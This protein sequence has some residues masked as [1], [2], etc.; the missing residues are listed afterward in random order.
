MTIA[1][2]EGRSVEELRSSRISR[3]VS[4]ELLR[5]PSVSRRDRPPL[6]SRPTGAS[7][8]VGMA[9]KEFYLRYYVG[10]KGKFGHEF[11]EFESAS[12]VRPVRPIAAARAARAARAPWPRVD[13][14]RVA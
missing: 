6:L 5:P 4:Q 8:L 2:L 13:A 10:H 3:G 11:M 12:R 7:S 9:S 14:R 1:S